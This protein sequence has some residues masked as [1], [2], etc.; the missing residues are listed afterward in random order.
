MS[1]IEIIMSTCLCVQISI[2][3][4]PDIIKGE[5]SKVA[6]GYMALAVGAVIVYP[7]AVRRHNYIHPCTLTHT[8]LVHIVRCVGEVEK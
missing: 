7:L 3:S 4:D 5:S 2:E 8:V 6:A 1:L